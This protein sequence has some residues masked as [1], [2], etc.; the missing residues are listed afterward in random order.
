MET[1][2][3][4]AVIAFIGTVVG[5]GGGIIASSR[6]VNHRIKKLE[7]KVD[8]HNNVIKRV[9]IAEEKLKVANHRI[10]A[11]EDKLEARK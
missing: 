11:C 9:F 3:A 5:S 2:I 10:K 6:L 7:E 4:V 1:D 8:K